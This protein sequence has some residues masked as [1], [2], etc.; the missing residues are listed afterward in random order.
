M[1]DEMKIAVLREALLQ[2][3]AA[4]MDD[5]DAYMEFGGS[6]LDDDTREL[7]KRALEITN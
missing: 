7:V 3:L 2:V 4:D 6:Q 5:H 1:N